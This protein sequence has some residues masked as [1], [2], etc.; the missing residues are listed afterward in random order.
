LQYLFKSPAF[1]GA[2]MLLN[3]K[4]TARNLKFKSL[5]WREACGVKRAAVYLFIVN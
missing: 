3:A 4:L 1:A 2:F 5:H